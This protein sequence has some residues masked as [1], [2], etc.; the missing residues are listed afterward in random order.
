MPAKRLTDAFVRTVKPPR[1]GEDRQVRYIDTLERGLALVLL[2]S[3]GGTKA[4][5]AVTYR[6]GKPQSVKLGTY[7]AMSL[8]AARAK[9]RAYFEDP[10]RFAAQAEIGT[11]GE[12]ADNWFKRHVIANKLL[13]GGEIERQL[14]KYV[15]PKWGHRK[16]LEIRRRDVNELL[17]HIADNHGATQ[18][19]K[20][21]ATVRS[22]MKFHQSRDEN[23]TTPIVEGM[24]RNKPK[25]RSRTLNDEEIRLVWQA[26][27]R[28]GTFG[29]L[30]KV[31]LLTA[32]RKDKVA[33][34]RWDD[35]VDGEW[36]IRVE[37]RG[38]GT[39]GTLKLPALALG[40]I[41]DLPRLAGNPHVFA[42]TR[43]GAAF[44][45]H[46][47]RKHEIDAAL[48]AAMPA[49]TLHDL[50]RTARSL[51]SRAGVFPHIAERVLGHAI[52]GVEQ[53]YDRHQYADEKADA[54]GK[55]AALVE[56]IINPPANNVVRLRN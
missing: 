10:D 1:E 56:R 23:Y 18:A 6:D 25:A 51:M 43:N 22:I 40:I 4:F 36:T 15:Y 42:G 39:A 47:Q 38:K 31:L 30:V 46:S 41:A 55:L 37:D 8:A 44:N 19:D 13:S 34:M 2:V 53:I 50:R 26:C 17:D 24:R 21:L 45:S 28:H 9:A 52:V 27:A 3:Y 20:V 49:W 35:L 12:I 16:F 33:G 29:A 48:P 14:R 5:R 32:Q 7:P 11:F 54:V